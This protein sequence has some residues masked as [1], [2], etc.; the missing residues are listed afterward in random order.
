MAKRLGSTDSDGPSAKP[1]TPKFSTKTA[2]ASHTFIDASPP[3]I[4]LFNP[5]R[6]CVLMGRL[7]PALHKSPLEPGAN[8]I[9]VLKGGVIRLADFRTKA[10]EQGRTIIP[11]EWGPN[12]D[13]YMQRV[14]T[15]PG[16][17]GSIKDAHLYVWE[18]A[19]LGDAQTHVDEDGYSAWVESLIKSK[20]IP[21]CPP[22][23]AQRMRDEM[24]VKLE[25]AEARAGKGDSGSGAAKIRARI[26]RE[27]YDVLEK[28]AKA[29][30]GRP[31]RGQAVTPA[32]DGE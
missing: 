28:A 30:K 15:R 27:Q 10:D 14:E 22:Y 16:G 5:I 19:A 12:G 23:I 7:I 1:Y 29:L 8:H 26:L 9:S 31:V 2:G 11:Y 32:M 21:A 3:F 25:T 24:A 6:W 18:T 4:L 13:S 20:K 17:R